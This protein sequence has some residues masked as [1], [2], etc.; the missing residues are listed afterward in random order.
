MPTPIDQHKKP[1]LNYIKSATKIVGIALKKR[2]EKCKKDKK[3]SSPIVIYESTVYPGTTEEICI[4]I[5]ENESGLKYNEEEIYKGFFCGYSPERINQVISH[6]L[7]KI[8]K[9]TSG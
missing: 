4:P 8:T 9:V 6:T 1:D 2:V 7:T 5:I 3:N